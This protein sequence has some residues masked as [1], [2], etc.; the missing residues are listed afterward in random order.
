VLEFRNEDPEKGVVPLDFDAAGTLYVSAYMGKDLA[1]IHRF[2]PKSNTVEPEPMA[3]VKDFDLTEGLVFEREGRLLGVRYEAET[4]G[5]Y[6]VDKNWAELQKLI[7]QSLPG[8]VNRLAGQLNDKD[9]PILVFSYSDQEP[10]RYLLFDQ[11]KRQ[12][13]QI[14]AV[15]PWIDS[16]AMAQTDFVR[17]KARDGL[18]IPAL[19]TLPRGA[20]KKNLPLVVMHYGGPWVRAIHWG[21]DPAVQFLASRGYAVLMP[22]PRAST[23]YGLRHFKAGWKQWGL[24]MQ[25]DVTD[26]VRWLIAQGTVDPKRVCIAGASYG[27]YLTMMG[28][29]KE[30]QLF[31][32]GIN[33][34]GVTDPD[35]MF[36]VSWTDFNQVDSG[37]FTMPLLI[38][39]PVKDAEQ[40]KQTSP[41]RRA[42]EIKQPVLMV[43][44][45]LD[46]RV[47]II[48]GDKMREAL[49]PHN[50]NVEWHV[51]P[52]EG[53]GWLKE[54]NEIDFWTRVE[55]FLAKNLA[56]AK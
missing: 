18:S 30:P 36:S 11:Q 16:K 48:N 2:D 52:D 24:A 31:R 41:L 46:Q 54:E 10:G 50:N 6:W 44:G 26:G 45:A 37:R 5:T 38:G 40:F 8:R 35:F 9:T 42:A 4:A 56:P 21:F 3:S 53:H 7:D 15:R 17:Y 12:L 47:P 20:E 27:G 32:C 13:A 34:V 29:V 49:K 55:A 51:Y 22:A 28:L 19:L 23:G 25:D 39:D 1:S 43:Y 33:W 14:A